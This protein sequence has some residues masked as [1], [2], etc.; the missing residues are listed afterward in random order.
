MNSNPLFQ[1][2]KRKL[3]VSYDHHR[4]G[5]R[6]DEFQR[7]FA[8][9]YEI[10]RDNSLERELDTDDAEAFLAHLPNQ[11]LGDAGTLLV[12]CGA[13]THLDKFVGW[14]I[15]AALDRGA[16]LLGVIL[17]DNPTDASGQPVLPERMRRNFDGGYAVICRWEEL[18]RD[19]IEL[20]PR[21]DFAMERPADLIDNTAPLRRGNE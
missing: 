3:F 1:R 17:P 5:G 16:G 8:S 2:K 14:E 21:I 15:K 4:D 19:K 11:G 6:Y 12:L 7:L 10:T 9:L 20:T 18:V 13:G